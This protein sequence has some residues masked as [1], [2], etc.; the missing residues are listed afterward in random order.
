MREQK[1]KPHNRNEGPNHRADTQCIIGNYSKAG[2]DF[3]AHNACCLTASLSKGR[4]APM[5]PTPRIH[6]LVWMDSVTLNEE[7]VAEVMRCHLRP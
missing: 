2:D 3:A 6:A 5:N 7:K 4:G 1:K